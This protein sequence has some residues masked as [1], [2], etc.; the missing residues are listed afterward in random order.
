[1]S[2]RL[3]L[4]KSLVAVLSAAFV[5]ATSSQ[6]SALTFF[7]ND[8]ANF[9]LAVAALTLAGSEDFES[10]TLANGMVQTTM[11]QVPEQPGGRHGGTVH[12]PGG[13][14]SSGQRQ[15]RGERADRV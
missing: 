2:R 9:D 12:P 10:S 15:L 7:I 11:A 5:V 1:M 14:V 8:Q 13:S 3:P 4:Q 6:V